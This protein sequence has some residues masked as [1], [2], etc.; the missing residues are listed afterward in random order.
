MRPSFLVGFTALGLA[1]TF[2]PA[3]GQSRWG[4]N[5]VPYCERE[6]TVDECRAHATAHLI[7][8]LDLPSA[9]ALAQGGY[10]GIRIFRYDAFGNI[11]PAVTVMSR[12]TTPYQREGFATATTVH[13]DGHV[14]TLSRPIWEGGWRQ[15]DAAVEAVLD[16]TPPSQPAIWDPASGQPP[17]PPPC[18][19]APAVKV[20]A[21]AEGQVTRWSPP[22]CE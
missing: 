6:A 1:S 8:K 4:P 22:A 16:A 20:E 18:L 9:E 17:P 14:A 21:I 15:V 5:Q 19:D 3:M 12:P 10:S 2:G 7:A 11:W 13:A